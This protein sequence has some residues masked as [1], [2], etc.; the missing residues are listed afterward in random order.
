MGLKYNPDSRI[1]GSVAM[2]K[3]YQYR[4][5]QLLLGAVV[6]LPAL[7]FAAVTEEQQWEFVAS[8][9][10]S[11]SIENINGD[12]FIT[13]TE[14]D[15]ILV[16]ANLRAGNEESLKK[17]NIEIS[18]ENGEI[19][20]ETHHKKSSAS[21]FH[22]GGS[23]SGQVSYSVSLPASVDLKSIETVNG[24]VEIE[25]VSASAM[26]STVNGDLRLTGLAGNAGL[27]TVNGSIRVEFSKFTNSQKAVIETVNG[28]VVVY[29]PADASANVNAETVNG[30]IKAGDFDLEA[31]KGRYVGS[32]LNGKIGEGEA[33]LAIETVNGSIKVKAGDI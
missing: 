18:E 23:D 32:D 8:D 15:K 6:L 1:Y 17:L 30:S 14:G 13:A 4:K 10:S 26:V 28:S 12:I 2:K 31:N 27:E 7:A 24:D 3:Q 19:C 5:L 33:R 29:L 9:D 22:W 11:L 21:W 25:G 20:F 16:T